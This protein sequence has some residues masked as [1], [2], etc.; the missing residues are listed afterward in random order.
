LYWHR[1]DDIAK[2]ALQRIADHPNGS[3]RLRCLKK[4]AHNV[5]VEFTEGRL[6]V[7]IDPSGHL[8]NS[9]IGLNNLVLSLS[10]VVFLLFVL[11]ANAWAVDPSK[12][13]TQYAHAA[14]RM[15]DGFLNAVPTAIART[16]DGYLWIRTQ[17][18]PMG[19]DSFR[20]RRRVAKYCCHPT[21]M[22][23]WEHAMEASGSERTLG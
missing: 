3:E 1:E 21:F 19:S 7:K 9:F 10:R 23:S 15:Q 17:A 16:T 4:G 13:M 6:A 12:Q 14:W 8:F 18:G 11:E 22:H 5:Q 20:G 2:T